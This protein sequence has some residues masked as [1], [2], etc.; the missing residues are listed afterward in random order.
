[1]PMTS[2]ENFMSKKAGLP[3]GTLIHIGKKTTEE[4][5]ISVFDY[6]PEELKEIECKN[7]EDVFPFRDKKSVS[8]IN[9]DGLHETE[10]IAK[11]GEH[12]GIHPLVLEDVL[13]TRLRPQLEEHDEFL[14]ISLKMLGISGDQKHIITEQ[15][16]F[17]LG[18]NW[19]ISFQER[20]GDIFDGLRHRAKDTKRPLR[21]RGNDYLLYRLLDTIVDHYFFIIEHINEKIEVLD[22]RV[23]IDSTNEFIFEVQKLKNKIINFR[24]V[25]TPLR[26]MLTTLKKDENEFFEESTL[27]YLNDVYDHVIQIQETVESQKES[28]T[29][30][31]ELHTSLLGHKMNQIMKVL[32][33]MASI[34]IP[35]TFVAGIYGMNFEYMP[36][37]G[38]RYG[39]FIVWGIMISI[40]IGMLIYFQ[41]KKWL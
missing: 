32:T 8:W 13:N 14:F 1:M 27:I 36:E 25:V 41:R 15:I 38:F 20:Q 23:L 11:L 29:S 7:I 4:Q 9:I 18:E 28:L 26:E 35:L 34:F 19:L 5:R 37:L 17:I 40:F 6:N 24:K 16:S 30:L 31:L 33:I 22:K 2:T 3:P 12:F 10:N 21:K 39:Y